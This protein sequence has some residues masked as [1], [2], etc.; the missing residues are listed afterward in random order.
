M[1]L[2][3]QSELHRFR[4]YA[5]AIALAHLLLLVFMARTT[6][7]LQMVFFQ[8]I[9]LCMVYLMLGVA[10][11]VV[12]VGAY[13]R[14]SEWLWLLHRP[15]PPARIFLA[16]AAAAAITIGI[17]VWL[18]MVLLVAGLDGFTEHVVDVRHYAATCYLAGY[19]YL[20][21]LAGAVIITAR[22]KAMVVLLPVPFMLT[23]HL[24][25]VWWLLVPFG[26]VLITM[27]YVASQGFR[28]DRES[29]PT[30]DAALW[31][32]ALPLQL[33]F[34]LAA[35]GVAQAGFV[36][37]SILLG[38]DPLNTEFPPAGGLIEVKRGTPAAAISLG[39]A[40][41]T[42]ARAAS[43]RTQLP[44]IEPV[45]L[46]PSLQRVPLRQQ[47][48]NLP[49]P[50]G[51]TDETRG[52]E[53]VFSHDRMLFVGRDP[54][55]GAARGVF[56]RRGA[57][58]ATAFTQVPLVFDGYV[59]TRHELLRINVDQ[60]TLH[61]QIALP[62][63]ESFVGLPEAKLGR[64]LLLSDR[65]LYAYR[66]DHNAVDPYAQPQQDWMLPLPRGVSNLETIYIAEL[67][68]GW[69]V[70]FLYGAGHRQVG[71]SEFAVNADPSQQVYFV[72]ADGKA[73]QVAARALRRDYPAMQQ[74][75]WWISPPLHI[76]S[77]LPDTWLDK[78]LTWPLRG[79][80]WPTRGGFIPTA[81]TLTL[82]ALIGAWWWLRQCTL[83][84]RRRWLWLA[85]CALVG[86]PAL[87]SLI[88]LQ[89]RRGATR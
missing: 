71:F 16:L 70:S 23:V 85:N 7:L 67:M 81:L 60:Q 56:G 89:P 63:G 75:A 8:A 19:C 59:L 65:A 12:Q 79:E 36:T 43:W 40:T 72:D 26:V 41:S 83:S 54:K 46:G 21:W 20:A 4:R 52:I 53:W 24:V 6:A 3:F 11:A 33:G 31:L 37:T 47:F 76:A 77:E 15:L 80:R 55:V 42:D 74:V 44:L 32:T 73:T 86:L 10:L 68:D 28:P 22:S 88:V 62:S 50:T 45:A 14:A 61:P 87:C 18:P 17:A 1:S 25:S 13:R 64:L 48:G 29:P 5:I 69:L 82:L 58:D 30:R 34:F 57:N 2:L 35:F 51:W 49:A 84:A 9:P 39:L 27:F 78:G 38:N 66:P